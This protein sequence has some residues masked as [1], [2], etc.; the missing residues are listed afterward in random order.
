MGFR[1]CRNEP[2]ILL[3]LGKVENRNAVIKNK[4]KQAVLD[5]RKK[6]LQGL[7]CV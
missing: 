2:T 6:S 1:K 7:L 3:F 4:T 5:L